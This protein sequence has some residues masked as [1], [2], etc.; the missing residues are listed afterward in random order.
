[1]VDLGEHVEGNAHLDEELDHPELTLEVVFVEHD[2]LA[3]RGLHQ[4]LVLQQQ[5]VVHGHAHHLQGAVEHVQVFDLQLAQFGHQFLLLL[6][7]RQVSKPHL[8][9]Q[10]DFSRGH[11]LH[12]L[13]CED[14]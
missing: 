14:G 7:R 4:P 1:V 13:F 2:A 5:L 10:S 8:M 11:A 3:V 9:G 12:P 6:Q